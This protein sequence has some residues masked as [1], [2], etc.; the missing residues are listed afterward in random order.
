MS[1]TEITENNGQYHIDEKP[2][3]RVF[4]RD[5]KLAI[6]DEIDRTPDQL[7]LILRREGLYSSQLYQWRLWRKNMGNPKSEKGDMANELARVRRENLRLAA[8]LERAERI[9][10]IQKKTSE[11]LNL[12]PLP[13]IEI[14]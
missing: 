2:K 6:L 10:E 11:F 13:A 14:A 5:K 9:I 12:P 4:L 8:K 3:R 7:G 1:K